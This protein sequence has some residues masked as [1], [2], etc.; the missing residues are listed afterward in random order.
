MR[1]I[2]NFCTKIMSITF[3]NTWFYGYSNESALLG[4]SILGIMKGIAKNEMFL[5]HNRR[6]IMKITIE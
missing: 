6:K 1:A 4:T 5:H 3:L 2:K